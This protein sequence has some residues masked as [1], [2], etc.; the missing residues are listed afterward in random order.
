MTEPCYTLALAAPA[1][2]PEMYALMR[3][4]WAQLEDQSVFAVSGMPIRFFED[5]V[6]GQ[7]FGV[8]ARTEDGELAGMLIVHYPGRTEENLGYDLGLSEEELDH[9]CCMD[10]ACVAPAH[11]GHRLE[12]R[13]LV[14]AEERLR[15][16]PYTILTCTVSPHNAASL[17]TVESL[18]Y[19]AEVTKEKFGG[20]LRH[21]LVKRRAPDA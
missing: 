4:V 11:R 15:G 21:V 19:R 16:T 18:G 5:C 8:T 9:V 1:E 12:R 6:G 2:V 3:G 17:R 7:G 14:W 10:T 20:F 13:M